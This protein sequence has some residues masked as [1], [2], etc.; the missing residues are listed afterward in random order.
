MAQLSIFNQDAGSVAAI[1]V[2]T[3]GA[4]VPGDPVKLGSGGT[5]TVNAADDKTSSG[6]ALNVST[7]SGAE[8]IQV[9][10][11]SERTYAVI[12]LNTTTGTADTP[13]IQA[14]NGATLAPIGSRDPGSTYRA[15]VGGFY[16]LEGSSG[17]WAL[18]LDDTDHDLFQLVGF[19]FNEGTGVFDGVVLVP[20]AARTIGTTEV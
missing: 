1:A 5:Y 7:T 6:I 20:S 2:K 14:A 8:T 11:W 13:T 18:G 4:I 15:L 10:P 16:S 12:A 17:S 3:A 9:V 19:V